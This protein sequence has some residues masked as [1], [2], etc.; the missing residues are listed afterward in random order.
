MAV[1]RPDALFVAATGS[2]SN[3]ELIRL[4][5]ATGKVDWRVP[6]ADLGGN[7][8]PVLCGEEV[9]VPDY[10]N[11]SVYAFSTATG[12]SDWKT[13]SLPLLFLFP[14][15]VIDNSSLFLAAGK[16]APAGSM[17]LITM[18]CGDGQPS[19]T[20]AAQIDGVSRT[21]VLRHA[22]S[23]ILSG[24]D[25]SKGTSLKSIRIKD[26]V[27]L[28]SASVPDEIA[29]FTPVIQDHL[30][31]AGAL[32][33]WVIDLETGKILFRDALPVSSLPVAVANDLVFFS[34]G[35][36]TVEARELPLGRLRWRARLKGSISSN[37]VVTDRH[38][39]VK[40]GDHE[41]ARLRL[42]GE[43]DSY[44]E[45]GKPGTSASGVLH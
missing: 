28:W 7:A 20:L 9:L 15:A 32:S 1:F 37:I 33:L 17:Q 18:S 5:L 38:V 25:R 14:P 36:H 29:R 42:T 16:K 43:I 22:D 44:I 41:L 34:R 40:I 2:G 3:S 19:R 4:N 39:Y 6:T 12:R 30:L 24:Y 21:P 27:Q 23:V 45:M 35:S 8:S 11:R 26:G 13:D 31:V 10:W